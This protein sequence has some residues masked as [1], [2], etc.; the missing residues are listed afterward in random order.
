MLRVA[1]ITDQSAFADKVDGGVQA[2]TKYL[3]DAITGL[4]S[5][6]LHVVSF[7][8]TAEE[9]SVTKAE[10]LTRHVLPGSR[11]G[12]LTAFR[13]DQQTLNSCLRQIAPDVVHGQGAG[14]DG[15][16][17]ARCPYPSVITIHGIISE[18]IQFFAN[19]K[20]WLQH[21]ILALLSNHY[22]IRRASHTIL[23]SP[24]VA[25]YYGQELTGQKYLI[26]NPIADHFFTIPRS[27]EAGRML[28]AGRLIPRKGVLELIRATAQLPDLRSV[29]LVLAGSLDDAS[30]VGKLR[31]EV[32][33][34]GLG[35]TVEFRGLLSERE[36]RAELERCSILVLPAHQETAPMVI[37]EAM[38]AGVPVVAT[39]VGGVRFQIDDGETGFIVDAGDVPG[40]SEKLNALLSNP[41]KLQ[42]FSAA[43]RQAARD[44]YAA[45]RIAEQTVDIYRSLA[46]GVADD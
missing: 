14:R 10:K 18:E 41:E 8:Y 42:E 34:L 4:D 35:D 26:P 12:T 38:A 22:C 11:L 9:A 6:D 1:M 37:A 33:T 20:R 15:I 24:Y 29:K 28:F 19:Q 21:R 31:Q 25:D 3:V 13:K 39:D 36:M 44:R 27:A 5:V 2:V 23:I 46:A 43:A 17:A 7:N 16:L 32:S 40:L 45:R 30:Y